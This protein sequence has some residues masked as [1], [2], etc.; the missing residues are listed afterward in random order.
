M[1][2]PA[3]DDK[4]IALLP[5]ETGTVDNRRA[6]S[7]EGVVDRATDVPMS[8][9]LHTWPQHLNPGSERW[10]D[11][12]ARLRIDVFQRHVIERAGIHLRK[13][14]KSTLGVGPLIGVHRRMLNDSFFAG[15]AQLADAVFKHS[16]VKYLSDCVGLI[17]RWLKE[18]AI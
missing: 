14:G 2:R 3:G 12:A 6:A 4:H 17:A 9:R 10:H 16:R 11:R 13:V 1:P 8:Q 7:L 18:T 5:L 15:R